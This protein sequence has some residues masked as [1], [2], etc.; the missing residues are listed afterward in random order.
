MVL[1]GEVIDP[2]YVPGRGWLA[3]GD[4]RPEPGGWRFPSRVEFCGTALVPRTTHRLTGRPLAPPS[5]PGPI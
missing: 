1:R 5:V 3:V 4:L 2:V